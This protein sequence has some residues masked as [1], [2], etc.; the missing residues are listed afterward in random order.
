MN[1]VFLIMGV[2]VELTQCSALARGLRFSI[3]FSFREI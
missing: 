3:V 2:F 1:C